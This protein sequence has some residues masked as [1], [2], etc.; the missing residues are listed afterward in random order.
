MK[1]RR[2]YQRYTID[3]DSDEI[4]FFEVKLEDI[5]VHLV[6]FS[7]GDLYVLSKVPFSLGPIKISV[8]FKNGGEIALP[9]NVVRV[10][11]SGGMWGIAVDLER[12]YD[13][14]SIR[15]A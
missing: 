3:Y 12:T 14:I 2:R 10:S 1:D 8:E 11:E 15:K 9:G 7:V 5:L 6:N 13:H 4:D